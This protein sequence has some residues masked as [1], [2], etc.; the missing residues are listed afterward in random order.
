MKILD[1]QAKHTKLIEMQAA[2]IEALGDAVHMLQAREE[3]PLAKIEPAA[4]KATADLSGRP[5]RV[6]GH[7]E[8]R[9]RRD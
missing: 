1:T 2:Q 8:A 5:G 9:D 3:T 6:A 7:L 4:L